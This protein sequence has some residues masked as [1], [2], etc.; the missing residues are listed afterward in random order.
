MVIGM[1]SWWGRANPPSN[2]NEEEIASAAEA[3]IARAERLVREADKATRKRDTSPQV[4]CDGS[5]DSNEEAGDGTA[6]RGH[7]LKFDQCCP[8]SHEWL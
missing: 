6:S 5:G 1:T 2:Q 7:H 4:R 8:T 3:E